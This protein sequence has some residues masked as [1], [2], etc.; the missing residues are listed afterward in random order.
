MR[1]FIALDLPQKTKDNLE[2]SAKQFAEKTIKGNFTKK[3]N[4]HVTLHFLGNV[5]PNDLIYIQ[6]AMDSVKDLPAPKLAV[7][8]FAI[9]RAGGVVCA[10]FN[11][12]G[13][14]TELHDRLGAKLEES[15]FGVEHRAYRPHVT[16]IRNFAFEL[17]FSE[18]TKSVDVYNKPFDATQV[19]L[20]ETVF[21]DSGVTYRKLYEVDLKAEQ[22]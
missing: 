3:E 5:N 4:Y 15:G 6:S 14:L 9:L 18:V 16:V 22:D 20:Y 21:G 13:N 7:N 1:V 2:R 12:D 8:Q 19:V 17:P 10:K 11:K